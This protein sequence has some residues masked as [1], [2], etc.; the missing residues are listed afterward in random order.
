M[1]S[2]LFIGK[3]SVQTYIYVFKVNEAHHKNEIVKFID[4]STDGYTRTNRKKA[5][6]NLRDTDRAKERYEELVNLVRFG[7]SKLS[8]FSEDEYYENTINPDDGA[9]WNQTIPVDTK[10]TLQDFKKTVSDY[11]EWEV[12]R[13]ASKQEN[14]TSSLGK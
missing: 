1:P 14:E 12:S 4:F 10:P 2:D 6:N 8:L 3:S 5:S 11:L 7:K 13:V 9:D